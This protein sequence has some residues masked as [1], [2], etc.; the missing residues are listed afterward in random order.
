MFLSQ[1]PNA[2]VISWVGL[3]VVAFF[4]LL[5]RCGMYRWRKR[6]GT[7]GVEPA[8]DK[9]RLERE[10]WATGWGALLQRLRT[11]L[12]ARW[13]D[14]EPKRD[15]SE[16]ERSHDLCGKSGAGLPESAEVG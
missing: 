12:D 16:V 9:R 14:R 11:G 15:L 3:P 4:S 8:L 2:V 7:G 6:G 5:A 10:S 13:R 1:S